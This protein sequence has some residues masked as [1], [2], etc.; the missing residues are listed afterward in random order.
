MS[1]CLNE[2]DCGRSVPGRVW[3]KREEK[4]RGMFLLP[5]VARLRPYCVTCGTKKP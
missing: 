3:G 1:V 5:W 2:R 4:Q